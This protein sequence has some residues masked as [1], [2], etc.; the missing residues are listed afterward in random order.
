MFL[1]CPQ[2]FHLKLS[3][4][5]KTFDDENRSGNPQPPIPEDTVKNIDINEEAELYNNGPESPAERMSNGAV[6][7]AAWLLGIV[8]IFAVA[9]L[10][11]LAV[12]RHDSPLS[13]RSEVR[14]AEAL[15]ASQMPFNP[16]FKSNPA[17]TTTQ[18]IAI[19]VPAG[20]SPTKDAT[21]AVADKNG[22]AS[23]ALKSNSES[24]IDEDRIEREAREVIN[25]EF[26]NN[27]ERK[28]KL[29]A[30]YA[31]VQERVNEILHI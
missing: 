18:F 11:A 9:I 29:G 5:M 27:P 26:G 4:I 23:D 15:S 14:Q 3:C 8:G 31:A 12:G 30:D 7:G 1:V 24:S 16:Q 13:I 28:M 20:E 6:K 17:L 2:V 19:L 10:V 25:G 21:S 22:N